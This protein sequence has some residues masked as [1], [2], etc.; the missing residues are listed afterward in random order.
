MIEVLDPITEEEIE[1]W[2]DETNEEMACILNEEK[3]MVPAMSRDFFDRILR[4]G[5]P[6][7]SSPLPEGCEGPGCC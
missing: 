7:S 6:V 1:S 3:R 5:P 2:L 4:C